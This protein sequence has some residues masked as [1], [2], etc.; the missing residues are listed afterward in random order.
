[1]PPDP[2]VLLADVERAGAEIERFTE[3]DGDAYARD[4][5][6]QAAVERKFEI[7]GE[8]LNRLGKS[9]PDL[10]AR[11]PRYRRIIDFRNMLIR[12]HANVVPERV[13]D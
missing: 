7:V 4:P 9:H 6:T 8:A 5:L 2:R 10:A 3:G 13:W 12:G 1:M 11:I